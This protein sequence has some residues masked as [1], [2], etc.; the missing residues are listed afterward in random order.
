MEGTYPLPEA[1][2]DRF[3]MKILVQYPTR[4]DLSLIV[5]RTIQREETDLSAQVDREG[6][7]RLRK[8]CR[9]VLVAPHVKNF[10]VDWLRSHAG[11]LQ[12]M[13]KEAVIAF[14]HVIVG[15]VIGGMISLREAATGTTLGPLAAVLVERAARLGDAFR[16]IV[17]AQLRISALNTT[18]T[19]I[20]LIGVLPALGIHLPLQKTMIAVTFIAG[21]MPVIG[22]LISNTV[23]VVVS[24]SNSLGAAV[25][26]LAY[27]VVIHKLEYFVNA[28]IVGAQIRA[29]AWELLLA[30]LTMEAAFGIPGLV[31]AP[32][33]YA[34]V[35]DELSRRRLI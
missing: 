3:L 16:R 12:L 5:E 17:F 21:L 20:Y 2:L 32:I 22:N 29:R 1:Q 28:R 14:V 8:L 9:D 13:G 35:K 24:L 25:G 33:Y 15:M 27:L 30:M 18:L 6:I 11:E 7:L 4:A 31:A 23:I 34:Y 26:S 19:A 10:A